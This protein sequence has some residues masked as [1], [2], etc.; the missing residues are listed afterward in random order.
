MTDH[1]SPSTKRKPAKAPAPRQPEWAKG[2]KSIYDSVVDEPLP[3]DMLQLLASLDDANP[4]LTGGK[5]GHE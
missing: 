5:G 4:K 3:D 1:A 2:L